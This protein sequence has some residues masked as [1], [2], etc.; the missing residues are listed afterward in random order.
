MNWLGRIV[1]DFKG[2]NY[3]LSSKDFLKYHYILLNVEEEPLAVLRPDFN[4]KNGRFDYDIEATET[5]DPLLL[6]SVVHCINYQMSAML[7]GSAA[8]II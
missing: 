1:I 8:A 4:M 6:L 3:L 2:K 5:I 7:S